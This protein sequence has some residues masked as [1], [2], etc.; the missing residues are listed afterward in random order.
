MAVIRSFELFVLDIPFKQVIK[1][2]AASRRTSSSLFLKCSVAAAD[3]GGGSKEYHGFGECLPRSY[4]T[5]ESRDKAFG[6]L[7]TTVLPKRLGM[8]FNSLAQLVSFLSDC[9]GKV[10]AEWL[11]PMI[12]Q[13]AAWA[14]VD[15]A[16]LDGFG[17]AL[18]EP[19]ALVGGTW[20][21]DDLRY[22]AVLSAEKGWQAVKT[23]LVYRLYGFRQAKLKVEKE[24]AVDTV[25]FCR[26]LLGKKFDL[27]VDANMA[28]GDEE[29]SQVMQQLSKL[30]VRSFEQPIAAD[31]IT[32]LAHLVDE[33]G[34]EVMAD[35]SLHDAESLEKLI[36]AGG[37]TSVKVRIS[38]CGGLVAAYN[39]CQRAREAGLVIQVGAQVGET[40]LLSSAQLLLLAAVPAVRYAEGCF[41][42]HLL[43]E[44][45]VSPVKQFGFGGT[46]PSL[47]SGPG[48]GVRVDEMMLRRHSG[49][50]LEVK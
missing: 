3:P 9:N 23:A 5:G 36:G 24:T 47:P 48:L 12:P 21:A 41:G 42:L 19:V 10:P 16:L 27:R 2:A 29:A 15:L 7:H 38:K 31:D 46:L 6:L 30:G 35:E 14:A 1:H 8:E 22:S 33:T 25:R 18:G 45:P 40:S 49:K 28:W 32:G 17:K 43:H 39:R 26:R 44:D 50:T 13:T 37:C 34:L 4:V 11:D 20:P